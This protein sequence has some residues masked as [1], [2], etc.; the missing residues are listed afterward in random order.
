MSNVAYQTEFS[1][2]IFVSEIF[3]VTSLNMKPS[4]LEN[5]LEVEVYEKICQPMELFYEI[6]TIRRHM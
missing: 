4:K 5:S 6:Q 2:T 1:L 3:E